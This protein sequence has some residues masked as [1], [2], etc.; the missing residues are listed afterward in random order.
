MTMKRPHD[1]P[2][3][4]SKGSKKQGEERARRGAKNK[5]KKNK[6]T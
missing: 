4:I 5:K 6:Q 3:H 1:M 2:H